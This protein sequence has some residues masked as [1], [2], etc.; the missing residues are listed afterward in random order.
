MF[1]YVK[2]SSTDSDLHTIGGTRAVA[3]S[4]WWE[5]I[6][7]FN[8]KSRYLG[9]SLMFSFV[10]YAA[11]SATEFVSW[12]MYMFNHIWFARWYFRNV[13]YWGSV[14]IYAIPPMFALI[15]MIDQSTI[16]FPGSWAIEQFV[17]GMLIWGATGLIH[18][19]FINDFIAYID[20]WDT[21]VCVCSYP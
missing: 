1:V 2:N 6:A 21:R 3:I 5:R 18:I 13:G 19:Y 10:L 11:V 16:V 7:E 17:S 9:L 4:W 14:V 8:G 15:Q 20:H 12:V